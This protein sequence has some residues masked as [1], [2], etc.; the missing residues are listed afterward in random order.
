MSGV[1]V[2]GGGLLGSVTAL[3]AA[4]AGCEVTLFEAA[5]APWTRASTANAGKVHLGLDHVLGDQATRRVLLDGALSF[6][7]VVDEAL[8]QPFPWAHHTSP[9]FE[10]LVAPG[11]TA[12]PED[13]ARRYHDLNAL[14]ATVPGP[15][16]Y[17]GHDIERIVDPEPGR[18]ATTGLP[19]FATVE[20]AVDPLALGPA[21][22]AALRDHPSIQVRVATRITSLDPRTG[23]LQAGGRDLGRFD[24]VVA[25]A[26]TGQPALLPAGQRPVRSI[27]LE[28]AVRLPPRPGR[29]TVTLVH[30]TFGDVVAFRGYTYA[31]WCPAGR[32]SHE[33]AVEPSPEAEGM[34][35]GVH[36]RDDV[37]RA[38]IDELAALGLLEADEVADSVAGDYVLGDGPLDVDRRAPGPPSRAELGV[39]RQDRLLV[40]ASSTLTTA[41]LAAR[42]VAE[43]LP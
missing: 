30:G 31:S 27:R 26:G 25:A 19:S 41:P 4:R 38:T 43:Q 5:P 7:D 21:F 35:M 22:L 39:T 36:I 24:A 29:H 9:P 37:A 28:A 11:S 6:A 14:V 42:L 32:L 3:L 15:R 34:R 33:Q 13:L 16:R 23:A 2:V 20:R 17:L 18:H 10:Y 40:P 8:G 12:T 1:A